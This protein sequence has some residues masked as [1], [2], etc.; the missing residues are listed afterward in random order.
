VVGAAVYKAAPNNGMHPTRNSAGLI[1]NIDCGR[2]M[3]GVRLFVVKFMSQMT[4]HKII[5]ALLTCALFG[6]SKTLACDCPLLMTEQAVEKSKAVFS[7]EVIGFEYRKGIPDRF[8]DEQ[9]KEAVR[10]NVYEMLVVKVRVDQWWKGEPPA[11]VFLLTSSTRNA[12]GTSTVDSCDYS[13]HKGETY[14]IFATKFN[15]QRENEYR[16]ND[17]S[18]TR[19]LSIADEDL[20]ILGEGKKPS[21]NKDEPNGSMIEGAKQLFSS[22]VAWLLFSYV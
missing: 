21:G 19:K 7:G 18:R 6:A 1:I 2:V 3:P 13:F 9:A 11:E 14:L 22:Q 5:L 16:T 4:I 12:D 20:K 15:T 8:V 10:S 17:C